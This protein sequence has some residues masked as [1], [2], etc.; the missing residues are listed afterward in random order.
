MIDYFKKL[1]KDK[2]LLKTISNNT[3]SNPGILRHDTYLK[4]FSKKEI[5]TNGIHVE[6]VY[7]NKPISSNR[8]EEK[9]YNFSQEEYLDFHS[10]YLN[11]NFFLNSKNR[12]VLE[13][14]HEDLLNVFELF[15]PFQVQN[16]GLEIILTGGSIR[17]FILGKSDQIK[18]LDI[19]INISNNYKKYLMYD[20]LHNPSDVIGF[21]LKEKNIEFNHLTSLSKNFERV[22]QYNAIHNTLQDVIEFQGKHFPIQL[23]CTDK[24]QQLI[25]NFDFDISKVSLHFYCDLYYKNLKIPQ[26]IE[27]YISRLEYG[28]EF[29]SHVLQKKLSYH[30]E[31]KNEQQ[32]NSEI[33]NHFPRIFDKYPEFNCEI[34]STHDKNYQFT[35]ALLDKVFTFK[36][37]EHNLV[38]K[39]KKNK[40]HKI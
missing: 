33:V 11:N 24:P 18:D 5:D 10:K 30:N 26:K 23:L 12:P 7:E 17:D 31:D 35:K 6:F 21:L 19:A 27:E 4:M 9:N 14:I 32:I 3:I 13:K 1:F 37:L 2:V 38:A 15:K 22:G 16:V 36:K 28:P 39:D 40:T 34:F 29:I 20:G 8:T 25:N